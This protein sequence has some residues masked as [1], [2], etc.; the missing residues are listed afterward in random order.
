MNGHLDLS[1]G[2]KQDLL[3]AGDVD[4]DEV[5]RLFAEHG[6][7]ALH[8]LRGAFALEIGRAHV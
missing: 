1:G 4:A 6:E 2:V 5:K 7:S 3:L 8:R